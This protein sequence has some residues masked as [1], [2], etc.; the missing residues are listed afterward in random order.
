[1]D[2]GIGNRLCRMMGSRAGPAG[3]S[4]LRG[5]LLSLALPERPTALL[6]HAPALQGVPCR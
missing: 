6:V 1:M 4:A 3:E 5:M 2:A